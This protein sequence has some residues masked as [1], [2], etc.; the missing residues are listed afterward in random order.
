ML[1][2]GCGKQPKEVGSSD[3]RDTLVYVLD[4]EPKTLDCSKTADQLA[5]TVVYQIHDYLIDAYQMVR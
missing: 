2:A 5:Y 3:L 4:A 1:L